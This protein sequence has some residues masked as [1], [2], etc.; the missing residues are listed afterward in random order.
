MYQHNPIF[1]WK[2]NKENLS[3]GSP[4]PVFYLEYLIGLSVPIGHPKT[5]PA[6]LTKAIVDYVKKLCEDI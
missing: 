2:H 3:Q 5:S 6:Y 1:A 4:W